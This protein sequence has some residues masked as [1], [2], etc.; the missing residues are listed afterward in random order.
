[1]TIP[2]D[3]GEILRYLGCRG[4]G[5]EGTLALVRRAIPLM[6]GA[7]A[8]RWVWRPLAISQEE[9]GVRLEGGLLLPGRDL[10]A[11]LRGCDWAVLLAA[12][13]SAQTDAL[14]R[15]T[16]SRDMALALALD[17]CATTAIEW[18]CDQVEEEVHAA[19]PGRFFPFR[20]SPGYGDLPIELQAKLLDLLDAP[21]KIG[22]CATGTHILTPRKSVTAL[23]GVCAREVEH[24][25]RSC[26]SCPMGARCQFRKTGGHCGF[27]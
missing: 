2:W 8:P 9:G 18:V 23:L 24:T 12:T 26:Q 7:M 16:E 6:E 5:D 4:P 19:F 14:I 10:A 15:R 13:L 1:M 22:L 11:H 20:F 21:R 17:C 27:A 25:R 3:E